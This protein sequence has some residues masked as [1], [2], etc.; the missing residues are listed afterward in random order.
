MPAGVFSMVHGA[1]YDAGLRLVRHPAAKAVGFT[2]SYRGGRA[3]FDAAAAR[4]EPIPVYAE[5]GSVNP[6]FVL[7]GALNA[8]AAVIG[9]GLAQ[10]V[11]LGVGQFCTNPGL[12]FGV[13][14]PEL[15]TLTNKAANVAAATAPGVMVYQAICDQFHQSI[16][17][18]RVM[19][20]VRVAGSST[21]PAK[22]GQ[23]PAMVFTTD[24]STFFQQP[25][26]REEI[27]GPSTLVVRCASSAELERVARSLPG[28]LTAVIHGT[29]EDLAQHRELVAILAD[30]A[31]RLVF[32]GFPTGV[33][34]CPSMHHG[35]PFPATTFAHFTSVGTAGITRFAR[36]V[37]FQNFPQAALPVELQDRN[38]RKVWRLV[39]GKFTQADL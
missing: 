2:G 29:E 23:A 39:D 7:P 13:E 38:E 17:Q 5:M 15:T 20:G 21:T 24:A 25:A 19:P 16:A 27:F 28:Q 36:P 3:L 34:V 32:N 14:S 30:K 22:S 1:N 9:E 12:V 33:E 8:R 11:T 31:G 18:W 4:P 26:L 6:V 10:S 37:C 35:G